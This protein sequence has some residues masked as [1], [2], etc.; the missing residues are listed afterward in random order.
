MKL[1]RKIIFIGESGRNTI[2]FDTDRNMA[3]KAEKS[4]LID[5]KKAKYDIKNIALFVILSRI[6]SR[7]FLEKYFLT[8][9]VY[10]GISISLILGILGCL[11]MITLVHGAL[12]RNVKSALPATKEELEE[13]IEGNNI[14]NMF[15]D[16]KVT[17]DK[18]LK[19]WF[20]TIFVISLNF[21]CLFL[22]N[23]AIEDGNAFNIIL[24]SLFEVVLVFFTILL[25]WENN[26]IR[27]LNVVEKYQKRNIE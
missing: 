23:G 10:N 15:N 9:N 24:Y 5:T 6:L 13:A 11:V 21:A 17:S 4:K 3:L 27:W 22:L 2:Y 14:W 20:I 26:I 18:K 12:Y 25:V 8:N 1:F 7:F 19:A 16:K